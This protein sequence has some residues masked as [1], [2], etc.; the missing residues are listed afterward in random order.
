[1]T[2]A[3]IGHQWS[4]SVKHVVQPKDQQVEEVAAQHVA[5]AEIKGADA[6]CREG[7]DDLRQRGRNRH[8]QAPDK[9]FPE[10][11]LSRQFGA[12]PRQP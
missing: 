6:H 8:K 11:C 5:D 4:L 1:V 2:R 10:P 3:R 7:D 9:C 12:Q